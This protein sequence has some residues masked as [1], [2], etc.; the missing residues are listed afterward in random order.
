MCC[1]F[2]EQKWFLDWTVNNCISDFPNQFS[3][4]HSFVFSKEAAAKYCQI[5]LKF[6]PTQ[7]LWTVFSK[8]FWE[9]LKEAKPSRWTSIQE[10]KCDENG[11]YHDLDGKERIGANMLDLASFSDKNASGFR[12]CN[13]WF[14]LVADFV[15]DA[16]EFLW[17]INSWWDC[18]QDSLGTLRRHCWQHQYIVWRLHIYT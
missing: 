13:S 11:R 18:T 14:C 2:E 16:V 17:L 6:G 3:P 5:E 9:E 12:N 7:K 10:K 8:R 15:I 1:T 4:S